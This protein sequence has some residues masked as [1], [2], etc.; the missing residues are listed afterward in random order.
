MLGRGYCLVV[1]DPSTAASKAMQRFML[2]AIYLLLGIVWFVTTGPVVGGVWIA[3]GLAG[4]ALAWRTRKRE[5]QPP[6]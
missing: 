6:I 3:V 1:R 4:A 5:N 2:A